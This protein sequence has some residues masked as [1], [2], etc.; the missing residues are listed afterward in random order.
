MLPD[1]VARNIGGHGGFTVTEPA[2]R[3]R[4]TAYAH[5]KELLTYFQGLPRVCPAERHL[6]R[7]DSSQFLFRE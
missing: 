4:G 6:D 2:T 7:Y 3:Q 5:P 1:R